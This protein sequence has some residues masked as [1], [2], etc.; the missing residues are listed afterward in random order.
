MPDKINAMS[1]WP[2]EWTGEKHTAVVLSES[3]AF[4]AA[5]GGE[6]TMDEEIAA[7]VLLHGIPELEA[8]ATQVDA[9][10]AELT[11]LRAQGARVPEGWALVPIEPT[12][13]MLTA[14]ARASMKH[15][16]DC[17]NDPTKAKEVGSE[18]MCKLTH[19]SRYRSMLSSAPTAPQVG[20]N[21][22]SVNDGL[23][24]ACKG[25][26]YP[27]TA[28]FQ[29]KGKWSFGD[30]ADQYWDDV[31]HPVTHWM[32]LPACPGQS[33]PQK[34]WVDD[35]GESRVTPRPAPHKRP[36][37]DTPQSAPSAQGGEA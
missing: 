28:V 30:V 6:T 1:Q 15:L 3:L 34:D 16:L 31:G 32:T 18:E 25:L 7:S 37:T 24:H 12:D 4:N 13:E 17:I 21:W 11:A 5:N 27:D 22:I 10:Q 33:T 20:S 14:A 36:P 35:E 2:K 19:A 26:A 8:K 29:A 9:L 23:P